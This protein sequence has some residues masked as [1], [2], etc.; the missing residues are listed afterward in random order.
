M[1]KKLT[2]PIRPLPAAARVMRVDEVIECLSLGAPNHWTTTEAKAQRATVEADLLAVMLDAYKA[3]AE[4][5]PEQ[6]EF[7]EPDAEADRKLSLVWEKLTDASRAAI[8]SAIAMHEREGRNAFRKHY[9]E[10]ARR[11]LAR[12]HAWRK[13]AL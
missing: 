11:D 3:S 4:G 2:K 12:R 6:R 8:R 1:K 5:T 9:P 7:P 13:G 10:E